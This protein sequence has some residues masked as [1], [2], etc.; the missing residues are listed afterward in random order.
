MRR[1]GSVA[2]G[3]DVPVRPPP[4]PAGPSASVRTVAESLGE[5]AAAFL[6]VFRSRA[7]GLPA[8]MS[9]HGFAGL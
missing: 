7:E 2:V 5:K 8:A 9:F 6:D 4:R 3:V 1:A